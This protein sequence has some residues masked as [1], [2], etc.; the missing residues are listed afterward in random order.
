MDDPGVKSGVVT[1]EEMMH[2]FREMYR[3]RRMEIAFDTEY[4][5]GGGAQL[6]HSSLSVHVSPIH[7]IQAPPP[8]PSPLPP[9]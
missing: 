2:Y 6:S 1:K 5:V 8:N 7:V 9:I 3:I 4:K